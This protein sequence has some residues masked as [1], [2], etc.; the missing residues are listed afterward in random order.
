MRAEPTERELAWMTEDEVTVWFVVCAVRE[1]VEYN[2][3]PDSEHPTQIENRARVKK[4]Y[5]ELPD[6][7]QKEIMALIDDLQAYD[8]R[9]KQF[10]QWQ[11]Y[12]QG[13]RS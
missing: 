8:I 11:R 5:D 12:L 3:G 1:C 9:H 4:A 2:C 10:Q 13:A 7:Y 6:E